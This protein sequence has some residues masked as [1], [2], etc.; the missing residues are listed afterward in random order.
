MRRTVDSLIVEINNTKAADDFQSKFREALARKGI[1][2]QELAEISGVGKSGISYYLR[3]KSIPK[4]DTIIKLALALDVD[5]KSLMIAAEK[6]SSHYEQELERVWYNYYEL[7][8]KYYET[9]GN[10]LVPGKC[11]FC[12]ENLGQWIERQRCLYK[13]QKLSDK[14]I[15]LL[16]KIDMVWSVFDLQWDEYYD[17]AVQYFTVNHNLLVPHNYTTRN[18][19]NLGSWIRRTRKQYKDGKLSKEKVELLDKIGMVWSVLDIQWYEYYNLA[20]EYFNSNGNLLIPLRYKTTNNIRLGLWVSHQ[21]GSY[22]SGKLSQERIELL[23]KIGM[24]WD[25]VHATWEKMYKLAQQYYEEH[26][27]LTIS[28]TTL[29][30]HNASLGGWI[31]TQ[32]KNYSLNKLTDKQIAML[33]TIGMEWV[34]TNNPDYIWEKNYNT[35]LEFYTK[36]KHLYIPINY[37]TEDETRLGVWLYDR[38]LE[39]ERNELSEDRR[40]KLDKLDKTWLESINTKSSFPEQAVL[41]YIKKS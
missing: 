19:M 15:G 9:N 1:N 17:L 7:A 24:E 39:Y 36:Y 2:Q 38:K 35:V 11:V 33:N 29:T 26:K 14:K 32:R 21:R 37:V 8:T 16:E 6:S 34:Y 13:E 22:K 31:G 18:G 20:V 25:G 27:N 12:E 28:D 30:Y 23:E 3:G 40:R 5:Y 10:L 41:Y 4:P